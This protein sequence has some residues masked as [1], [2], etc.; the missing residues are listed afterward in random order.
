MSRTRA[1]FVN[2]GRLAFLFFL[3]KGLAWLCVPAFLAWFAARS[4]TLP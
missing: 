1:A 3:L 2:L 4:E